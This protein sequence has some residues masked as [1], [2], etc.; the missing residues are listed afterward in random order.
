MYEYYFGHEAL[1]QTKEGKSLFTSLWKC[2]LEFSEHKL[3]NIV[4]IDVYICI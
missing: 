3:D 4:F 2:S 1:V